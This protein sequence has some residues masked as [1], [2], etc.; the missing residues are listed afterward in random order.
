MNNSRCPAL[1]T[2]SKY[3]K[4]FPKSKKFTFASEVRINTTIT[5]PHPLSKT[6]TIALATC[7]RPTKIYKSGGHACWPDSI[8]LDTSGTITELGDINNL[9]IFVTDDQDAFRSLEVDLKAFMDSVGEYQGLVGMHA[10]KRDLCLY[11]CVDEN[12]V[13]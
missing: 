11:G 2:S 8:F 1:L 5:S 3:G 12:D 6:P 7:I 9:K 10:L 13:W 4:L